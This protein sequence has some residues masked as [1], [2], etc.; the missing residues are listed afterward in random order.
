MALVPLHSPVSIYLIA[1]GE[2]GVLEMR[3]NNSKKA[4][5]NSNTVYICMIRTIHVEK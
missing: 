4:L 2:E 1:V 5:A 3:K